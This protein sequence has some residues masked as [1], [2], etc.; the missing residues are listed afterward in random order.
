MAN[1]LSRY[2]QMERYMTYALICDAALFVLFLL[3]AAL[4][5]VWLKVALAILTFALSSACIGYLFLTKEL[6][7]RRSLWMAVAAA[8]V[9]ICTLAAL[10]LNFPA[11][12][13][14]ITSSNVS[15]DV[16]ATFFSISQFIL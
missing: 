7:R 5:I 13:A 2:Q 9:I 3:A 15:A 16:Q 14:V 12:K 10:V 4:G 1:M 8:A 11:P 6:F